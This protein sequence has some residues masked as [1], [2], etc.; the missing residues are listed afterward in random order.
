MTSV[1]SLQILTQFIS[2]VFRHYSYMCPY[3]S[4]SSSFQQQNQDIQPL[5]IIVLYLCLDLHFMDDY[6]KQVA[7]SLLSNVH[8]THLLLIANCTTAT[9]TNNNNNDGS[10]YSLWLSTLLQ[11]QQQ[12]PSPYNHNTTNQEENKQTVVITNIN[13]DNLTLCVQDINEYLCD[14][15]CFSLPN[16]VLLVLL[17]L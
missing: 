2:D 11:Q 13:I 17:L 4:S 8:I 3:S 1:A 6:T 7:H 9:T 10:N 12:Q 14:C 15:I 5:P 16:N